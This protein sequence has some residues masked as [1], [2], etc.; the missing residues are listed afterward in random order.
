M[1]REAHFLLDSTILIDHLN[2]IEKAREFLH[3]HSTE[4]CV[5]VITVNE[6]LA[7]SKPSAVASHELL[8]DQFECLPVDILTAKASAALRRQYR[9]KLAD[10]MQAALALARGLQLVTRN[11]RHFDPAKHAFVVVPYQSQ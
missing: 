3:R 9:W 4:S 1:S 5:S 6:V 8:L 10:S 7:G 2:G 11:H